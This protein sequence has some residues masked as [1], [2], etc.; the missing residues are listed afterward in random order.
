MN[1]VTITSIWVHPDALDAVR[2]SVAGAERPLLLPAAVR[3]PL[4]HP[5]PGALGVDG[6]SGRRTRPPDKSRT[7]P[8]HDVPERQAAPSN[9]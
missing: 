5:K 2:H 7:R 8:R 6:R 9:R 3:Q 4:R 1:G